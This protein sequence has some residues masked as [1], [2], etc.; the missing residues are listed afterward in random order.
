MASEKRIDLQEALEGN[1]QVNIEQMLLV[2]KVCRFGDGGL[3]GQRNYNF[4][5]NMV[6]TISSTSRM[7][8]CLQ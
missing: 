7:S 2:L 8:G 1:P 5:F 4:M 3:K 6:R